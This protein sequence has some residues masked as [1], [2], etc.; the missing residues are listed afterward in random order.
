MATA[1][2]IDI[3]CDMGE[4]FG[5]WRLAPDEEIMPL[6]TSANV[7]CGA[8]AGDPNVMAATIRLAK[9]YAVAVGAHPSYPDLNGFGR[10]VM[11]MHPD[12]VKRWVLYQLGALAALARAEGVELAHVKPHGA[13]YNEGAK[14][15]SLAGAIVSAVK[16][17]ST[18]VPLFCLP[19]SLIEQAGREASLKIVREGFADR[20]YEPNGSLMDR[21]REGAVH[22]DPQVAAQQALQLV[23]GAV[24]CAGGTRLALEVE[25]ICVHSDTHGSVGILRAIRELFDRE[26]IQVAA[27]GAA[28]A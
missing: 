22:S 20:A 2:R 21:S 15:A 16:A 11:P 23:H 1:R 12:E 13:L 9:Q 14:N 27:V 24:D 3:N 7:A 8:H 25:T 28:G 5:A 19:G 17:F 18:D 10:R 6:V 4:G 26:Q